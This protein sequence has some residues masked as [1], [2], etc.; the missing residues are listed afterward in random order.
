MAA[1]D[2]RRAARGPGGLRRCPP[3]R[4]R[5]PG[6]LGP[7][8]ASPE[9]DRAPAPAELVHRRRPENILTGAPERLAPDLLRSTVLTPPEGCPL[10]PDGSRFRSTLEIVEAGRQFGTLLDHTERGR[11]LDTALL[12]ASLTVDIPARVDRDVPL[13][14]YCRIPA[15]TGRRAQY[16]HVLVDA[17]SGAE[18]GSLAYHAVPVDPEQYARARSA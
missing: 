12:W 11:P 17:S 4:R 14:L 7:D 18:L 15:G 1:L 13:A 9:L 2:G 6:G 3:V 16:T 8:A 10:A 5:R